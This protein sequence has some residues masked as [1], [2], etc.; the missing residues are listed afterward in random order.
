VFAEQVSLP[1]AELDWTASPRIELGYRFSQ[2][3]GEFL[4]A[5]HSVVS[6]GTGTLAD[7]DF[8]GGQG[9]LKTRLDL[10]VLDLDYASREFSL[11]PHWDMKWKVGA[12]LASVFFDSRATG[13]FLD[14]RVSNQ[15]YGAGP[16]LGL[17][18]WRYLNGPELALFARFEGAALLGDIKQTFGET[19]AVDDL[20][21]GGVNTVRQD[22]TVPVVGLQLG[23][24]WTPCWSGNWLRFAAGYEIEQWWSVGRAGASR[25]DLTIQG[26]FLRGE[27][28]F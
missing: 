7:F 2:G 27:W 20:R 24:G 4:L 17:D 3:F 23:L 21:L 22:Q 5:Y 25:G 13:F 11:G 16:H 12:R 19:V 8:D 9:F 15:F 10:N 18:L 6:E 26:L 28:S 1:T 14:Q